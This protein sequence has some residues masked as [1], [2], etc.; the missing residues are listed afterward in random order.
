MTD[1]DILDVIEAEELAESLA[2]LKTP[3]TCKP[4]DF[5]IEDGVL[6]DY[7]GQSSELLIPETVKDIPDFAFHG[8][9]DITAVRF[10]DSN[11]IQAVRNFVFEG[12]TSLKEFIMPDYFQA[13]GSDMFN[14]CT[15]LE[16]VVLSKN[17]KKIS[18]AMFAHCNRLSEIEIP[19]SVKQIEPR[20]FAFC[21]SLHSLDIPDSVQLISVAAFSSCISMEAIT[22]PSS[23]KI[24]KGAFRNCPLLTCIRIR[25]PSG[26]I[27]TFEEDALQTM[28]KEP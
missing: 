1:I 26:T 4:E 3:V 17:L 24:A 10:H 2:S 12:C 11:H 13:V 19:N 28:F 20:A 8:R 5:I 6:K 18:S 22:L 23:V 9:T 25:Y 15:G 7:I 21:S 27:G 14:N 16:R